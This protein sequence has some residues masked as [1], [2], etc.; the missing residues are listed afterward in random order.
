MEIIFLCLEHLPRVNGTANNPS[1][2][3]VPVR[4]SMEI[5]SVHHTTTD[6]TS[7][8]PNDQWHLPSQE[9]HQQRNK[10]WGDFRGRWPRD[11]RWFGCGYYRRCMNCW[12]VWRCMRNGVYC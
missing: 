7:I 1:T 8:I 5:Q 6:S 11:C 9:Q 3:D 12:G 10:R 4:Q 2:I